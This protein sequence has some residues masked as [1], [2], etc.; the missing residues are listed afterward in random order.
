MK[1]RVINRNQLRS[2]NAEPTLKNQE[3]SN[4]LPPKSE[5]YVTTNRPARPKPR[6]HRCSNLILNL[7]KERP[8][9][10][11]ASDLKVNVSECRRKAKEDLW[12]EGG[13]LSSLQE[14][15]VKTPSGVVTVEHFGDAVT[16]NADFAGP[17]V[18]LYRR[19]V[20]KYTYKS[21]LPWSQTSLG[22]GQCEKLI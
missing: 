15:A 1:G 4:V 18:R 6:P 16:T 19:N 12:E 8:E 10:T 14:V 20:S 13:R 5:R 9:I 2:A 22:A 17:D 11:E 21:Q 7:R 3:K